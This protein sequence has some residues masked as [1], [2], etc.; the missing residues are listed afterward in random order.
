MT[1]VTG[2]L[3]SAVLA[4]PTSAPWS[5]EDGGAAAA[6]RDR[7][8]RALP[9][10]LDDTGHMGA[11]VMSLHRLRQVHRMPDGQDEPFEWK[12]SFVRRSLG[13]AAIDACL[14]HFFGGPAA[15]VGPVVDAAVA[16]WH[17]TGWRTFHWEPWLANLGGAARAAVLAEA[18]TWAT[19]V[20]TSVD[21]VRLPVRPRLGGPDDRWSCP[22]APGVQLV[23]RSEMRVTLDSGTAANGTTRTAT[24]LVSISGGTPR[25][26]WESELGYLAMVGRLGPSGG[27]CPVRVVG[28]WPEAGEHRVVEVTEPIL[29]AACDRVLEGLRA[30]TDRGGA[31][32]CRTTC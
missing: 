29:S 7:L 15:A 18:A 32:A 16:E 1:D 4:A 5:E 19:A 13:L 20:W 9:E 26:G 12:P 28:L 2:S 21:W 14:D 17:R 31:G 23:A 27:A 6:I 11:M 25:P 24:A 8:N 30:M 10:L 22:T 3:T